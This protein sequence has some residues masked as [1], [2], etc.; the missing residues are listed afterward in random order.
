MHEQAMKLLLQRLD[1]LKRS[2]KGT[3]YQRAEDTRRLSESIAME[4]SIAREMAA[5]S[6]EVAAM[7]AAAN[8]EPK[9]A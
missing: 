3:M 5:I 1:E 8:S 4:V 2:L 7:C 9:S 6:E